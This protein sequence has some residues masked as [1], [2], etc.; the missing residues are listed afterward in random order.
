MPVIAHVHVLES[1]ELDCAPGRQN[2][3][4]A[5]LPL[6]GAASVRVALL[7]LVSLLDDD[8]T[9]VTPLAHEV[10]PPVSV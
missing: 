8:M 10:M 2:R 1:T 5:V 6:V 4:P 7:K 3:T 9:N